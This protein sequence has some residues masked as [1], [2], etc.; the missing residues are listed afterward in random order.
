M[1]LYAAKRPSL[2]GEGAKGRPGEDV[3]GKSHSSSTVFWDSELPGFGVRVYPTGS[4]FYVAQTRARGRPAKRV[5]LGRHGVITAEEARRRA[6]HVIAQVKSGGEPAELVSKAKGPAVGEL[7]QAWLEEHVAV[8]WKPRTARMYR[9]IVE[10][11]ILPALAVDHAKTADLHHALRATPVMANHVIDTL[12]RIWNAAVDRGRLP[13][14]VINPCR[15][16]AR[17]RERRRERFLST[18]EFRRLGRTLTE[19]E[20]RKGVSVHAVAAIR[21]LVLTGCRKSEILSLRWKD[22]DLVAGELKLTD[23][24]TGPRCVSLSPDAAEVL[25]KAPRVAGNPWVIPG[26]VPGKHMRNLSDPWEIIRER[27]GLRDVRLHDLRP[28]LRLARDSVRE[29]ALEVSESIA[30]DVLKG[31][32][33]ASSP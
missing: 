5:T 10:R 33:G 21:L 29:A 12:S 23:S 1:P 24:K 14:G 32:P 3:I 8:R 17:N 2:A 30:A 19:A 7:A 9:L 13:E 4:R 11:H 31:Y 27:A 28:L 20:T 22:V 16:V 15:L 18:K 25:A 26:K 6:A